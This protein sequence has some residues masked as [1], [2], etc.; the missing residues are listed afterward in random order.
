MASLALEA[1]QL[2]ANRH[3]ISYV[4]IITSLFTRR[5]CHRYGTSRPAFA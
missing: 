3:F 4:D 1:C 2:G 5:A